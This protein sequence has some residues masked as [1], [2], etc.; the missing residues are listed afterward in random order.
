[1][2]TISITR[3]GVEE[4]LKELDELW[5][6]DRYTIGRYD[7]RHRLWKDGRPLFWDDTQRFRKRVAAGEMTD[8]DFNHMYISVMII[9]AMVL[10][11]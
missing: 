6:K 2:L 3:K 11:I 4:L 10:G 1:M 9:Q 5:E 8:A 7:E